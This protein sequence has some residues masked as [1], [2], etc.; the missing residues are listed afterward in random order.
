MISKMAGRKNPAPLSFLILVSLGLA[1][2]AGAFPAAAQEN[3]P[4][5]SGQVQGTGTPADS[6]V[7]GPSDSSAQQPPDEQPQEQRSAQTEGQPNQAESAG[8]PVP[9]TWP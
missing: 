5:Q 1:F 7:Q 2:C 6:Q 8:V 4:D 9:W 3:Q